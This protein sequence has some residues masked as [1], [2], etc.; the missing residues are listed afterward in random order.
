MQRNS[1]TSFAM[2]LAL[3]SAMTGALLAGCA[4]SAMPAANVSASKA[5]NALAKGKHDKAIDY[6]EASV[7]AEPRNAEYRAM[8]GNAYLDAGRFASAATSFDDAMRLGDNTARTALSL[9]LALTGE[10]KHGEAAALLNDWEGEI[11]VSDLGLALTIAGQPERGIHLMTNAIRGGENTAKMRQNLAFSYAMAGRWREA[12]LM[13]SQDVPAD[14][15]GD[16]MQEWALLSNPN[17]WQARVANLLEVPAGVADGGQPTMLALIDNPQAE[18]LAAQAS[19]LENIPA[20]DELPPVELAAMPEAEAKEPA[21]KIVSIDPDVKPEGPAAPAPAP[22]KKFESAFAAPAAVKLDAASF[23]APAPTS[24]KAAQPAPANMAK[25]AAVAPEAPAKAAAPA[26]IKADGTHMVQLGSF[27]SEQGARRAW[28][29]YTKRYP[30]LAGHKMIISEAMVKGKRYWRV[31]AAGFGRT[32]SR[33]MCGTVKSRGDG[34]FAYAADRSLPGSVDAGV[35][36]A[37]R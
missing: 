27:S 12:R 11:P 30:E 35:R 24:A 23:A 14:K 15:V 13:A 33:S 16:R 5:E 34:C 9:A 8:L 21:A 17:A 37:R 25:V 6:A 7:M 26:R 31:A 20:Q 1:S 3:T 2:G 18:Q 29:I 10:G 28:G 19:A 22:A 4:T 36:M 32:D